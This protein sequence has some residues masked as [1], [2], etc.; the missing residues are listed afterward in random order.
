MTDSM[1]ERLLRTASGQRCGVSAEMVGQWLESQGWSV[2]WEVQTVSHSPRMSGRLRADTLRSRQ[3]VSDTREVSWSASRGDD[4][5]SHVWGADTVR[6]T[7]ARV[8]ELN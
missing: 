6:E 2:E 8:L 7:A 4:W 1:R 3:N 5:V